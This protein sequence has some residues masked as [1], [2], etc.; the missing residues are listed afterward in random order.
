MAQAL[1]PEIIDAAIEGFEAQINRI[2]QHIAELR[3][4]RGGQTA[5]SST[6]TPRKRQFSED[7]LRRMREAQQRRW[8]RVRGEVAP[9]E[10]APAKAPR[11]KRRLSAAGRKANPA[12]AH[13]RNAPGI[14]STSPAN[15]AAP[16]C[17][18]LA[19]AAA[20]PLQ[21]NLFPTT[22]RSSRVYVEHFN[23]VN[24]IRCRR[25]HRR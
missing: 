16:L 18:D 2:Q 1:T 19:R 22:S 9:S 23:V 12:Q 15:Q 6:T 5:T 24:R 13:P 14:S 3:A 8:A 20:P 7:A 21:Q 11:K 4:M 10:A 25:R 17:D